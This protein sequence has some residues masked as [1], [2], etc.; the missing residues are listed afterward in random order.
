MVARG[1]GM[2]P[3][4]CRQITDSD[5]PDKPG[6]SR[7]K[8]P[9]PPFARFPHPNTVIALSL[10]KLETEHDPQLAIVAEISQGQTEPF[11]GIQFPKNLLSRFL[12]RM[13]HIRNKTEP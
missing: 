7:L 9:A 2:F 11:A 6:T 3:T 10:L 1:R 13:N 5:L 12:T 4:E 8:L